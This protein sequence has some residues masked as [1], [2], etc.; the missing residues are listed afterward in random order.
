MFWDENRP[1]CPRYGE[2]W[3]SVGQRGH[4]G[5]QTGEKA[6]TEHFRAKSECYSSRFRGWAQG[7][8]CFG[9]KID[10]GAPGRLRSSLADA[11][12][13]TR[14]NELDASKTAEVR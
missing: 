6:R 3:P 14:L 5:G 8:V 4:L 2:E 10:R 9:S 1:R 11:K 12:S 7:Q 13:A